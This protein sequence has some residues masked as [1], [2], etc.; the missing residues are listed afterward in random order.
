MSNH[1]NIIQRIKDHEFYTG[2]DTDPNK[3]PSLYKRIEANKLEIENI[4][5]KIQEIEENP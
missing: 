4:K 3:T 2:H 5:K 1:Q